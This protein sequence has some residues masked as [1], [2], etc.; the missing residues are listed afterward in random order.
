[1][2]GKAEDFPAHLWGQSIPQAERQLLLLRQYNM[3]PNISAYSH[4]YRPHNYNAEPFVT[5][6]TNMLVHKNT[7][8]RGTFADH[9]SKVYILGTAFENHQSWVM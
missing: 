8:R 1:M 9:Y 4:V 2:S 5:I 7:T 6:R 3:N